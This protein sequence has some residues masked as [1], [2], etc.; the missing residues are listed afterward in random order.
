MIPEGP[1]LELKI[2]VGWVCHRFK[3][4]LGVQQVC[5]GAEMRIWRKWNNSRQETLTLDNKQ[6]RRTPEVF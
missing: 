6:K 4:T 1:I 5:V 3:F 2:T